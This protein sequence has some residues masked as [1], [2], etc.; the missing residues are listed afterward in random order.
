MNPRPANTSRSAFPLLFGIILLLGLTRFFCS[1][2][3]AQSDPAEPPQVH[4]APKIPPRPAKPVARQ[5]VDEKSMRALI[6]QLVSCGSRNSL[7]SWSDSARRIGCARDHIAARLNEIAKESGGKL[8]VVDDSFDATS[9]RTGNKPAHM[10]NLY[11]ILTGSDPALSK[12]VF[13]VSGHF[14]S[15][16]SDVMDP[17]LDAPGADDDASGV[18][19][20]MECARLL[21]K[22]AADAGQP[23]RATLLFAAISGEEQG[24]LGSA[25][26][27]EWVKQQGYT[28]GGMLDNDIVGSDTAAGAP[29]R[30]RPFF[31]SGDQDD[32]DSASPGLA[33]CIQGIDGRD[34]ICLSFYFDRLVPGAGHFV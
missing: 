15:R 9:A 33:P 22:T 27:L 14:D 29:P 21:S 7:S 3:F 13:I 10:E 18:A 5:E 1:A 17:N 26:M 32:N 6:E 12:T 8:R 19:V 30:Q 20:S 16:A 24:L 23:F 34:T 11:A 28:V 25:R 31:G 2:A 4:P